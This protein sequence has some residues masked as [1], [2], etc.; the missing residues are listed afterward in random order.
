MARKNGKPQLTITA[1]EITAEE[2]RKARAF[3]T[4]LAEQFIPF[5]DTSRIRRVLETA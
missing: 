1:A 2:I 5:P 3:L 4:P